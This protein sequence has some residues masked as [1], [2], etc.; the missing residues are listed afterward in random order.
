MPDDFQKQVLIEE[1]TKNSET[2][3][4][5]GSCNASLRFDNWGYRHATRKHF[6]VRGLNLTIEAGQRVLLLGASGIGKSTI[7]EGAAGIIGSSII[8]SQNKQSDSSNKS[9]NSNKSDSS[10]QPGSSDELDSSV[11]IEDEDGGISEGCVYVDDIPVRQA[12]GKV[13]LVLQDPDAQ[14]IFQR[15]GDNVAFGPENMNIPREQIWKRVEKSIKEVGLDGLQLHRSTSHLSGGQLQRLALAGA[16]AMEPRVLLLDEPTANLDPNGVNQVVKA[17]K[18]VLD[19]N[20]ATMVLVEHHAEPWIDMIDRV[21]VLGLDNND[22]DKSDSAAILSSSSAAISNSNSESE[23]LEEVHDDDIARASSARTVIVADGSPDEVFTRTD[24]DFEDLGIW[25][26]SKYKNSHNSSYKSNNNSS[27]SVGKVILSTKDLSISHTDQPIAEHINLEFKSGQITALVGANGAGKSTLSLT[28]AGLLPAVSGE[29][30]ASDELSNGARGTNPIKWKSSELAKRISYVFQNPEHQF[31]CATVLQEVMLGP[32]RTGMSAEDARAKAESL[33]KRFRLFKYANSNPYTLSGGE[34]RR[35]TVAASLAAAP[36][37]I[38]LDEPTFGQDRKTWMQIIRL[39]ESLNKDGVCIIVVTHDEEL[40][41]ALN[42]RVI[43][44]HADSNDSADSKACKDSNDSADS[45]SCAANKPSADSSTSADNSSADSDSSVSRISVS[46]VNL[47]SEDP[48][49]SSCSPVLAYMNPV[50]RMFSAFLCSIPLLLT[51]DSL[52]ASVAL[53]IEFIILACIKIPPWK[54]IYLSWPVWIGAPTSAITIFLYGKSG[55]STW[56][57]WGMI[58]VTDRSASLAVATFLR[59]LAIGIPSIVTVIGIDATDLADAFSQILHL[60]DRFVYGGLAGIRMFN[61]LKDDWRALGASRR[62]RGIGDGNKL[63]AFFPQMF[64]LLV[65]SI[66]RSTTL[67]VA[68]EARGFGGSTP[69]SH[70]RISKVKA[71]DWILLVVSLIIPLVA[72]S[73]A[74]YTGSFAFLGGYN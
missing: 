50:Y 11:S 5:S 10:K 9:D 41:E 20:H 65:L 19:S 51:L 31:A 30:V 73:V 55:G 24:L 17:V 22:I 8:E 42:A 74:I 54:V 60:P 12:R 66:R 44:L 4:P 25:L 34:K 46:N 6:A 72:L 1:N 16:L 13:G 69:R 26:P 2:F 62:S 14:A 47:R 53:A 32:L 56:F 39:I 40:V 70:A 61:V 48:R 71:C 33:L 57:E 3:L 35:L 45:K 27:N 29:V 37:V 23:S 7:L 15:L 64:A 43:E 21:V 36:S 28:L 38:I 49:K 58:H 59:I 52:S 68:M 18:N 63:K 67:A